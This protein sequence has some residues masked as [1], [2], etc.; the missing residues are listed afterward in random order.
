MLASLP[1]PAMLALTAR[2][3]EAIAPY[4]TPAGVDIPGVTLIASARR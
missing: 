4:T 1:E 2:L 3:R